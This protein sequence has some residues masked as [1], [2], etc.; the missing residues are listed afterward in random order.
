MNE[1]LHSNKEVSYPPWPPG[2]THAP[3]SIILNNNRDLKNLLFIPD[4][5]KIWKGINFVTSFEMVI[6]LNFY[7]KKIENEIYSTI[8][9]GNESIH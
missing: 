4:S 7:Q 6:F 9:Q 1:R 3:E 5:K 2:P 8:L